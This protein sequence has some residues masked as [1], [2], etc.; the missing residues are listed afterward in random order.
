VESATSATLTQVSNFRLLT[1]SVLCGWM[2]Q[3]HLSSA[4]MGRIDEEK[5]GAL[6]YG[7]ETNT[8]NQPST[9]PR[10][11]RRRARPGR[12]SDPEG[13][14]D[15]GGHS[16]PESA[17]LRRLAPSARGSEFRASS[18][19]SPPFP[20]APFNSNILNS[21][22]SCCRI[23]QQKFHMILV[24]ARYLPKKDNEGRTPMPLDT[25]SSD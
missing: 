20:F 5:L 9:R 13:Q 24:F 10:P 2:Q 15:S 21:T 14:G 11:G 1:P 17:A 4:V 19:D 16:E 3:D 7:A 25:I 6:V 22:L 12:H 18:L 23:V 8:I